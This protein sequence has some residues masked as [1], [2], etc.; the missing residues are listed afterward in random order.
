[1]K[2]YSYKIIKGEIIFNNF[3]DIQKINE[4]IK[5]WHNAVLQY[6]N[7]FAKLG[8]FI[9]I[10]TKLPKNLNKTAKEYLKH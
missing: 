9:N 8:K 7:I 6:T 3:E 10:Q 5:E 1:M 4:L 2:K